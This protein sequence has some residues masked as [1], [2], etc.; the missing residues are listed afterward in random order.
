M[1]ACQKQ[2]LSVDNI[3]IHQIYKKVHHYSSVILEESL[4]IIKWAK[5][6]ACV[7]NVAS[8]CKWQLQCL[9]DEMGV[10]F[11]QSV[12]H[13]HPLYFHEL[14]IEGRSIICHDRNRVRK[15]FIL[16]PTQEKQIGTDKQF[17]REQDIAWSASIE[18]SYFVGL[19]SQVNFR[20]PPTNVM[21]SWHGPDSWTHVSS[22]SNEHI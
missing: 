20:P 14:W 1:A 21:S 13:S 19:F 2:N 5:F 17:V 4:L 6:G 16:W 18:T 11:S 10:Q 7:W 8:Y 9:F 15:K 22:F 12:S 3:K